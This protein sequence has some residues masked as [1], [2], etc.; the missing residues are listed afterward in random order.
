MY[1]GSHHLGVAYISHIELT[2]VMT[3]CTNQP[4]SQLNKQFNRPIW[5]WFK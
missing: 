1:T 3:D 2:S 5:L 4:T